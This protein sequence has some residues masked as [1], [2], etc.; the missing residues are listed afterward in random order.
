MAVGIVVVSHSDLLA[1]GVVELAEQMAGDVSLVAAGGDGEG[2]IGTSFDLILTGIT[3]ADAGDGVAV[4]ADLGSAVMTAEQAFEFLDPDQQARVRLADAPLAEG[5]LAA[6]TTA[7][8]GASLDEVVAAAEAAG[9]AAA[10]TEEAAPAS[11][12][13]AAEAVT[14]PNP[15]GLHARPAAQVA[16]IA[17]SFD[18]QV[19]IERTDSGARAAA[20]SLLGVVGL[21]ADGGTEVRISA[22]GPDASAAVARLAAMARDGFGESDEDGLPASPEATDIPAAGDEAGLGEVTYGTLDGLAVVAGIAIGLAAPLRRTTVDPDADAPAGDPDAERRRLHE[23]RDRVRADLTRDGDEIFAAHA[24]LLDDPTLL[25][26]ADARLAE[27]ASAARAWTDAA[28]A[29]AATLAALPGE[30]FAARA[31]DV[32]D[33]GERVAAALLGASATRIDVREGEV[34]LTDDVLPSHVPAL[35]EGGA[36]GLG[37]A[38]GSRTSHAAILANN[39]GLPLVVGLGPDAPTVPEGTTVV[40]DGHEGQ[41]HVDPDE[42]A[43]G[44]ARERAA[45]DAERREQ[46][47]ALA[48]APV[49]TPDGERV[50]I[51]A[52]ASTP[53]EARAAV[54]AGAEAIGLLRTEFMFTER[55][56]LPSEDEQ[57]ER[58]TE[59][60]D[61]L[62]D[63]PA[64]VRTL[65]AGGDKDLPALSLDPVRHGFLGVRG[66]RLSLARPDVF[67]PQLRAILRAAR[68][69][70]VRVMFPM[71][72]TAAEVRAARAALEEA[73]ASLVADGTEHG[74]VEAVGIMVEVPSAALAPDDLLAECDFVSV[75]S[76][77][78]VAYTMAADRTVSDVADLADPAH[79]AISRLIEGLCEAARAHGRWVGVCGE[80]AGDPDHA[81]RLVDL[82][83]RELS[84]APGAIAEVKER[85]LEAVGDA[86]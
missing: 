23:A 29:Q 45:A 74:E 9:G 57:A 36:A 42:A 82:G 51:A 15:L 65:D 58:L 21:G 25:A 55:P 34:V 17:R 84:M 22:S 79:P 44:A 80:M 14:L 37:L 7:A 48:A 46:L 18:A 49:H 41:L 69:R 39:L 30:A 73:R 83:V 8:G 16:E 59:V 3:E 56:D 60:L 24:I 70:R 31:A 1:R 62:G 81:A 26:D 40:L 67:R 76:N 28:E 68:G 12:A 5:T 75:G 72:T 20:H 52:N 53:A 27:G 78:L 64:I 61:A 47:R 2:G 54:E 86:P 10:V 63:R 11:E 50:E 71:V 85:L 6:A 38:G 13:D 4:M 19:A 43:L 77:D 33:V 66:L 32:R 35:V